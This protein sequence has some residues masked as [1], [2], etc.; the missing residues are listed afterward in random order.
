MSIITNAAMVQRKRNTLRFHT[1]GMVQKYSRVNIAAQNV[2]IASPDNKN[3]WECALSEAAF[4]TG[5]E[6]NAD[7][8]VMTSY[9]PLFAHADGGN[10]R[11]I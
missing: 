9:A 7:V 2:A 10:G 8:V 1:T 4:M 5:L 6:R 11:R 3:N